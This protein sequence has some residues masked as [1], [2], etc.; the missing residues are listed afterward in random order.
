MAGGSKR[1]REPGTAAGCPPSPRLLAGGTKVRLRILLN[2]R[3][4]G[5]ESL[6]G[7]HRRVLAQAE[8]LHRFDQMFLYLRGRT[9][10]R[11][12]VPNPS[13][14]LIVATLVRIDAGHSTG[15][16]IAARCPLGER[17]AV[18]EGVLGPFK[19]PVLG[20]GVGWPSR[21]RGIRLLDNSLIAK[22]ANASDRVEMGP[23]SI[24]G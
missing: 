8:S 12:P 18:A 16:S 1:S 15:D 13:L 9:E 5:D 6:N 14:G 4:T 23:H 17:K 21:H 2:A 3:E 11:H 19:T 24:C 7:F 10:G 22:Q 20:R